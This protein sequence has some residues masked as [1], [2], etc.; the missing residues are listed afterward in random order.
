MQSRLSTSIDATEVQGYA[1][2][3]FSADNV[4]EKPLRYRSVSAERE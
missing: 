3:S 1:G 2:S 4:P